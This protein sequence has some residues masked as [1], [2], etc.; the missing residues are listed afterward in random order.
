MVTSRL[1]RLRD[2]GEADHVRDSDGALC[3]FLDGFQ[4]KDGEPLP[5]IARKSDGGFNYAASDLAAIV[6][7]VGGT[8]RQAADLR[9]RSR[10]E[11]ALP[12]GLRRRAEGRMG[13]G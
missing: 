5:L 10:T 11:A 8:A 12:D 2:G 4:S 3:I 13:R 9:G 6:Q 7:R 1:E